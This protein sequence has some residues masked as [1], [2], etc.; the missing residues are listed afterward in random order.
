MPIILKHH[1]IQ[2]IKK[3]EGVPARSSKEK[4]LEY[5]A[6][7][8]NVELFEG[9]RLCY[10]RLI[11]FGVHFVPTKK[12]LDKNEQS[13]PGLSFSEF[14]ELTDDLISRRL[15]GRAAT[16]AIKAAMEKATPEEWNCWYRRI[17]VKRLSVG[18][19]DKTINKVLAKHKPEWVIPVFSVQLAEDFVE[20]P[21]T[22]KGVRIVQEKLDGVRCLTVVD[23]ESNTVKMY[24]RSGKQI[25]SFSH[26]GNAIHHNIT[27]YPE[28]YILDGELVSTSFQDV[29]TQLTRKYNVDPTDIRYEVFDA[30]P[31]VEFKTGLSKQNQRQRLEWISAN[32]RLISNNE[33]VD[34]V[35]WRE[36][37]FSKPTALEEFKEFNADVLERGIEGIMIK[38][39]VKPYKCRRSSFWCKSKPFITVDLTII[40]VEEGT[41]RNEGRLGAFVCEGYDQ[42][43]PIYSNVG[44]GFTDIERTEF[45][46]NRSKMKGVVIEVK[47]DAVTQNKDKTYSLRFPRFYRLR[48]DKEGLL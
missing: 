21:E 9:F 26:I 16:K 32:T 46:E 20:N 35:P 22:I 39:P 6:R 40:S 34:I 7:A 12:P 4:I 30:F 24:T 47:A 48:P 15:S 28:S 37:D 25:E 38:D 45:W 1:P 27:N 13:P 19:S 36:I 18:V 33:F 8:N 41:G 44:S 10:D 42:Y 43:R 5:Q 2:V 11:S 23:K 14:K 3:L 17:L 31:L 29:M